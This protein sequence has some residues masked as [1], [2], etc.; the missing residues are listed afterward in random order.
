M[1]CVVN[2]YGKAAHG[3][4]LGQAKLN[5]EL[6]RRIRKQHAEKEATKRQ[7]DQQYSAKAFAERYGVHENTI[8][9]VISYETWRH[10]QD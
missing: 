4:E 2:M 1:G 7:L 10:V 3:V 8:A 5:D 9:K 6:V